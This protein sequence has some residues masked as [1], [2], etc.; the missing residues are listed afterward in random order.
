[1]RSL[2]NKNAKQPQ[3][4]ILNGMLNHVVN[5]GGGGGGPNF[6]RIFVLF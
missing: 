5:F 3:I 6:I 2:I 4:T 1:M